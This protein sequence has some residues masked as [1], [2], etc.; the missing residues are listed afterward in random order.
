MDRDAGG[1]R[2][3][4]PGGARAAL[5]PALFA[6]AGERAGGVSRRVEQRQSQ[7]AGRL[8]RAALGPRRD[9]FGN[10][11]PRKRAPGQSAGKRLLRHG[12]LCGVPGRARGHLHHAGHRGHVDRAAR[13]GLGAGRGVRATGGLDRTRPAGTGG[14]RLRARA[15]LAGYGRLRVPGTRPADPYAEGKAAFRQRRG[16]LPAE[17]VRA[18][19]DLRLADRAGGARAAQ[20]ADSWRRRRSSGACARGRALP[21]AAGRRRDRVG[22]PGRNSRRHRSR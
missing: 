21:R 6:D 19:Y 2:G 17:H 3:R 4:G 5:V 10:R 1:H 8:A 15:E 20:R 16:R 11:P 9:R 22:G 7:P 13:P 14:A 18:G 12:R